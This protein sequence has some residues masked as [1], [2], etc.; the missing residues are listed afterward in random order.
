MKQPLLKKL[1]A[2]FQNDFIHENFGFLNYKESFPIEDRVHLIENLA[3]FSQD[4]FADKKNWPLLF[5]QLSA[6]FEMGMLFKE[7]NLA[8]I[9]FQG[10]IHNC[11]SSHLQCTIPNTEIFNIYRT[12]AKAFLKSL[13]LD[14]FFTDNKKMTCLLVRVSEDHTY[15][16]FSE[17]AE[18]WLRLLIE[19]LQK[20]LINYAY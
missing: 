14:I 16:L 1:E 20:T 2:I 13:K 18:P 5:S 7:K 6:F 3:L 19:S 17:K 11:S 12:S 10:K 8:D 9:F 4:H 15:V